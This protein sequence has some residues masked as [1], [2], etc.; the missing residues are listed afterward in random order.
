[1]QG[2]AVAV[3]SVSN[4]IV[5]ISVAILVVLFGF[6]ALGT[7]RVGLVFAPIITVWM[8]IIGVSGCINIV[9]FPGILRA[10]DPSRAV[11]WFVRNK[12]FDD[13]GGVLLCITGVEAMLAKYVSSRPLSGADLP[14]SVLVNSPKGRYDSA[15]SASSSR[16]SLLSTSGRGH[17]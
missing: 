3:P 16:L 14:F 5:P 11:M 12:N 13:L 2:I 1:M 17:G 15:S 9:A 10:F 6:Q 7:Q 8:L 4:N